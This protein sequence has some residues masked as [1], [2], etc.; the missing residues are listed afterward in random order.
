MINKDSLW[1][2][3]LDE[4]KQ[5]LSNYPA[6]KLIAIESGTVGVIQN[7]K[8][9]IEYVI[10]HQIHSEDV[11]YSS[12]D[13]ANNLSTRLDRK[14]G[15]RRPQRVTHSFVLQATRNIFLGVYTNY[16][17][18]FSLDESGKVIPI[19]DEVLYAHD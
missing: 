12:A 2:K 16:L 1:Q 5:R 8:T 3:L 18:G 9:T 10:W 11:G 13:E 6:D 19:S 4:E 17:A 7:G 14:F 15:V